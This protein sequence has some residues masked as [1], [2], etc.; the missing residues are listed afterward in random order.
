M[1]LLLPVGRSGLAIVAGYLGLFSL[2][3]PLGPFAI[4]VAVLAMRDMKAHPEKHG[5]G[6]VIFALI[7]GGL[8]TLILLVLIV[9]AATR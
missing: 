5:M 2:F 1:R 8:N 6:R 7:T 9:K 4:L 3:L